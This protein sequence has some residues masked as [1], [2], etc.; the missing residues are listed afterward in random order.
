MLPRGN[1]RA[2]T[3]GSRQQR[4]CV[5]LPCYLM[6]METPME[7]TFLGGCQRRPILPLETKM[8]TLTLASSTPAPTP[9]KQCGD[10]RGVSSYKRLAL[11]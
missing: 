7:A 8:A 9:D 3:W 5:A 2:T 1:N 10:V 6:R 4:H 11:G